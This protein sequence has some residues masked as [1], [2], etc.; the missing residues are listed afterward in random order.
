M[1]P[2]PSR[3]EFLNPSHAHVTHQPWHC[4]WAVKKWTAFSEKINV[5]HRNPYCPFTLVLWFTRRRLFIYI[6]PFIF[7]NTLGVL[8]NLSMS[9]QVKSSTDLFLKY[10]RYYLFVALRLS[11]V[12]EATHRIVTLQNCWPFSS[13]RV[14]RT[15]KWCNRWTCR[16]KVVCMSTSPVVRLHS[17]ALRCSQGSHD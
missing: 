7:F 12:C 4:H 14:Y 1:S 15:W 17:M 3:V 5:L 11:F 16:L 9:C 8:F 13:N 10:M 2:H 6:L